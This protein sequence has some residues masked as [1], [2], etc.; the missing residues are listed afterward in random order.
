MGFLKNLF[1]SPRPF[2]TLY[3][4]SVVCGQC[5]ETIQAQ[6]NVFNEPSLVLDEKGKPFYSCRKVLIGNGHCF[7]P[8][9]VFFRFDPERHLLGREI[10]GGIF[11][12]D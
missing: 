6:V 10:T 9:E 11:T 2:K 7:H 5:G 1:S 4:F 8:V 12:E 3:Q